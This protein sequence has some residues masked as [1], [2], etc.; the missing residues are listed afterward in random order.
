MP[1][2]EKKSSPKAPSSWLLR[3]ME[4]GPMP[5]NLRELLE[6]HRFVGR[7]N[8]RR[9]NTLTLR[10]TWSIDHEALEFFLSGEVIKPWGVLDANSNLCAEFETKGEAE[11]FVKGERKGVGRIVPIADFK[12][13]VRAA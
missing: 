10:D 8:V 9:A 2:P 6:D 1:P 4:N 5:R 3:Q 7:A 11:T 12:G 13:T